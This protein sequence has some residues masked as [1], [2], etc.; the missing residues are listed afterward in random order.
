MSDPRPPIPGPVKRAVRQECAFGCVI[1]GLPLYEYDHIV[2]YAE[3]E[4]HQVANLVLLCDLH[5]REKT[6]G[7][8]PVEDVRAAREHPANAQTGESAGYTL[9]YSHDSCEANIASNV[10]VTPQLAERALTA[11]LIVDDTP[12]VMFRMQDGHLLLTVRLFDA[13]NELLVQ[14]VDNELIYSVDPWDVEFQGLTLTVRAGQGDIFVRMTFDPPSR[15]QIDRGHIWRNG[16][17]MTLWPDR[18]LVAS[19]ITLAGNHGTNS[20]LGNR[21]REH[22]AAL[23]HVPLRRLS[24]RAGSGRPR[25]DG[26]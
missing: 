2:P 3:V 13:I 21:T 12:I 25:H 18:M 22:S 14:I 11:P 26:I 19:G 24:A 8:L 4:E 5:H 17:E 7:L 15:V 6:N 16:V 23:Q 20:V 9:H 1:C 10:Y